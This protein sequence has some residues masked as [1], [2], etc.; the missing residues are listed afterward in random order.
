MSVS[1]NGRLIIACDK[2]KYQ[3]R[4]ACDEL[5]FDVV[6]AEERQMGPE[7]HH[8]SEFDFEC[9]NCNAEINVKYSVW[10]YPSGSYNNEEIE[11]EG[12][13]VVQNCAI[14]VTPD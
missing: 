14:I 12:G 6:D 3:N 4:F 2:C 10:E 9:R 1:C 7:S 13:R 11:V 5:E 8:L